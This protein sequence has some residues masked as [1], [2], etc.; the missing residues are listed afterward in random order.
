MSQ[1]LTYLPSARLTTS[2]RFSPRSSALANAAAQRSSGMRKVR[3]GVFGALGIHNL[4]SGTQSRPCAISKGHDGIEVV[5]ESGDGAHDA[6]AFMVGKNCADTNPL[7]RVVTAD[8]RDLVAADSGPA[9]NHAVT[10]SRTHSPVNT[11]PWRAILPSIIAMSVAPQRGQV[12]DSMVKL[13]SSRCIDTLSWGIYTP[14]I[15][16]TK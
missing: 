7:R 10:F 15:G 5:S 8:G 3:M 2:D 4:H 13:Q 1:R 6:C 16:V 11:K 14:S 9:G 12:T